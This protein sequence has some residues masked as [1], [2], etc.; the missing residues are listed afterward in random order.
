MMLKETLA[1]SMKTAISSV[2]ETMFFQP[3]KIND[4]HQNMKDWFSGDQSLMGARLHFTGPLSGECYILVPDS[5]VKE[6]T[7]DF[8]GIDKGDVKNDQIRDT[9]K[10][11]LNMIS[12]NMLSISDKS[13]A[14]HI[15]I[16][17]LMD[18]GD[19]D[20]EEFGGENEDI[21]YIETDGKRLAMGLIVQ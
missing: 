18:E 2:M 17:E 12:G 1:K 19:I 6:M 3:V 10:E 14:F 21:L 7:A 13:S 5:D 9:V 4:H 16:P 8:L 11:T 20:T 15:G